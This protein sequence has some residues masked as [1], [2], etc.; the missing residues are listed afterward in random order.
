VKALFVSALVALLPAVL[1]AQ[2]AAKPAAA[3]APAAKPAAKPASKP[4]TARRAAPTPSRTEIRSTANQMATGM[5]AAEAA[6]GPEEIALGERVHVGRVPCELG[7]FVTVEADPKSP[8]Y[9]NVETRG[10]KYRMFPVLSRTGAI[11]LEDQRTGAIWLQLANKSMLMDQRAGKRLADECMSP[12]QAAVAQALKA[13]PAPSL[14][15]APPTARAA[16]AA[17]SATQPSAVVQPAGMP[18]A[19]SAA[20]VVPLPAASAPAGAASAPQ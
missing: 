16:S 11:R 20:A 14:L 15:D 13:N 18:S 10:A 17:A 19:P 5:M 9:F 7:A 4:A 8:G 12:D 6:L 2:T 3:T 1:L